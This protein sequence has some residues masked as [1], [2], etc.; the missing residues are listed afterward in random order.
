MAQMY[1][2]FCVQ[3]KIHQ[4]LGKCLV[5]EEKNGII[6]LIVVMG[7]SYVFSPLLFFSPRHFL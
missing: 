1:M 5:L 2:L 7:V 4:L 6:L 3:A